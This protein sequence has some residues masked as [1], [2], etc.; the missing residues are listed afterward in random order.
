MLLTLDKEW[1]IEQN[2]NLPPI[3][4]FREFIHPDYLSGAKFVHQMAC[5]GEINNHYPIITLKRRLVRQQKAWQVVT[6]VKCRTEVLQGLSH[7]DFHL[8]M[9]IDVELARINDVADVCG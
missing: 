5:I 2:D 7:N 6:T 4:L 1:Q 9:L 3:S 8:A